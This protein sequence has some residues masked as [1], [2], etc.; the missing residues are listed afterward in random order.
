LCTSWLCVY[1]SGLPVNGTRHFM[2]PAGDISRVF[3]LMCPLFH[4]QTA[5]TKIFNL[6]TAKVDTAIVWVMIHNHW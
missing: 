5:F 4:G 6:L 2:L 3:W 1:C